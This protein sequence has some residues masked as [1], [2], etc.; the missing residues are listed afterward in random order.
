MISYFGLKQEDVA[1]MQTAPPE[2]ASYCI[3]ST[4]SVVLVPA[5]YAYQRL[6]P[7][8]CGYRAITIVLYDFNGNCRGRLAGTVGEV[9]IKSNLNCDMPNDFTRIFNPTGDALHMSLADG[10]LVIS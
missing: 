3:D 4:K 7:D 1:D 10:Y 6:L 2:P 5:L 8:P 9:V